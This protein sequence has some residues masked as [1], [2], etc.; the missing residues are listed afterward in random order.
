MHGEEYNCTKVGIFKCLRFK[1]HLTV[2]LT[3]SVWIGCTAKSRAAMTLLLLSRKSLQ[4][5]RNITLTTAWK[6][7][8]RR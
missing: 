6:T 7:V 5:L 4:T 2:L 3:A 1:N 8:F